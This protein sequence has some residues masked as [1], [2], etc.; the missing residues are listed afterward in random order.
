MSRLQVSIGQTHKAMA[1]LFN[2]RMVQL[3][4]SKSSLTPKSKIGMGIRQAIRQCKLKWMAFQIISYSNEVHM[5]TPPISTVWKHDYRSRRIAKVQEARQLGWS[6]RL[7]S[8]AVPTICNRRGSQSR[9]CGIWSRWTGIERSIRWWDQL[10]RTHMSTSASLCAKAAQ[11]EGGDPPVEQAKVPGFAQL[12][13]R[14]QGSRSVTP[15]V[16]RWDTSSNQL[17]PGRLVEMEPPLRT[18]VWL[19]I[20]LA[21][22]FRE[23]LTE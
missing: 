10:R 11:P 7:L 9:S 23:T 12:L 13:L 16:S 19:A 1:R 17:S 2:Q 18:R 20:S 6:M 22:S 8:R 3:I 21:I 14:N 15:A 5:D 4:T